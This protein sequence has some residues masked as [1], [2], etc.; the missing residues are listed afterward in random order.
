MAYVW[1]ILGV[2]VF[3]IV[4]LLVLILMRMTHRADRSA[5]QTEKMLNP[6]S[7]VHITTIEVADQQRKPGAGPD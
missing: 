6:L 7:D 5:R 2:I 4:P 3:V 1:L